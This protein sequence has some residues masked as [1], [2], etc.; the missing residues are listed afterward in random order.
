MPDPLGPSQR[1]KIMKVPAVM[2]WCTLSSVE[3]TQYTNKSAYY[4]M[5]LQGPKKDKLTS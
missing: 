5:L 4:V 1:T 3:G 2:E